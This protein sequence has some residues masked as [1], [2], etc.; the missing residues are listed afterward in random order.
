M[1]KR[2]K[3]AEKTYDVFFTVPAD[4]ITAIVDWD[5]EGDDSLERIGGKWVT[6]SEES[7][8]SLNGLSVDT[9]SEEI[10][11][12]FDKAEEENRPINRSE[13]LDYIVESET[14]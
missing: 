6:L 12:I 13:V 11:D 1:K 3:M 14:K 7:F 10:L 9:M 2:K 5:P 8:Q 4:E